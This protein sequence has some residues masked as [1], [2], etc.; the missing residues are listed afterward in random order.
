M[1]VNSDSET[2]PLILNDEN[3]IDVKQVDVPQVDDSNAGRSQAHICSRCAS[4]MDSSPLTARHILI[5][6]AV[7][8]CILIFSLI[9]GHMAVGER[10]NVVSVFVAIWTHVTLAVLILLLCLG[11]RRYSH[12][13]LSRT[14][15]QIRVLCGL[16]TSWLLL[17]CGIIT[18]TANPDSMCGYWN[19]GDCRRLFYAAHAFSWILIVTLFSAAFATYRRA[20]KL[21]GKTK[22]MPPPPP[23]IPAWRLSGVADSEGPMSEGSLKI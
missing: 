6:L 18:L 4:E 22:V 2:A 11:R 13:R 9:V 8:W 3:Q 17:M 19:R 15:S 21:Y 23:M 14:V 10:A 7:F 16:A 12:L 5:V 1:I 20:V